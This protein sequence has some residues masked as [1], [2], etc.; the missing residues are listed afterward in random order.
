MT[1]YGSTH[2]D[3]GVDI[4]NELVSTRGMSGMLDTIWLILC[5]MCFGGA[6]TASGMLHSFLNAVFRKLVTSR[7]GLV[8]AT[9]FNGICMNM[10]TGDQY[11][12]IILTASMFKDIYKK[13]GYESKLLSRSSEDSA[14]VTSVLIPWNTCGMTQA[15]VLGVSTWTYLPYCFFN[16]LSPLMS[17]AQAALGWKIKKIHR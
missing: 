4:L 10:A 2:V 6:M 3:T 15:S 9:I 8:F 13:N 1:F 16:L 5:A 11:I 14:T 7:V 12:S 17:I